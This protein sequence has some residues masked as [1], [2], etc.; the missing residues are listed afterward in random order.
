MFPPGKKT[1]TTW[2]SNI[3]LEIKFLQSVID[4]SSKCRNIV[5]E[6]RFKYLLKNQRFMSTGLVIGII[7]GVVVPIVIRLGLSALGTD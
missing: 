7:A 3:G 5:V 6:D 4:F 1:N 2:F